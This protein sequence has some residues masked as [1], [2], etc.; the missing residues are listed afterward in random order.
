MFCLIGATCKFKCKFSCFNG[1]VLLEI[2]ISVVNVI[3][4]PAWQ[5]KSMLTAVNCFS[6]DPFFGEIFG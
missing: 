5:I 2:W 4:N 6:N 3:S 1:Y